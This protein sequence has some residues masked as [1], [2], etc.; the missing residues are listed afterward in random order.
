MSSDCCLLLLV[1]RVQ[2]SRLVAEHILSLD[3]K[4]WMRIATRND[5]A[6]SAADKEKLKGLADTVM[7]LVDAWVQQ[8]ERQLSDS[9]QVLQDILKAAAD[10]NGE[11]YLPLTADQVRIE[12]GGGGGGRRE[13]HSWSAA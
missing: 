6:A 4:F 7:V 9:A 5:S 2:L 13:G 8:S 1:T 11:W 10:E 12:E 3:A